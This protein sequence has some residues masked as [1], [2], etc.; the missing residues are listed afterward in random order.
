[1]CHSDPVGLP[2]KGNL[3]SWD[4]VVRSGNDQCHRC[5]SRT[6]CFFSFALDSKSSFWAKLI[7]QILKMV[8]IVIKWSNQKFPID[9]EDSTTAILLKSQIF[10][11]TGVAPE[12]QKIMVKGGMLKDG[13]ELKSLGL[14][15]VWLF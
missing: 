15:D 6:S 10:S 1:M 9:V 5:R 7:K 11:L 14:K 12:R 2:L 8:Q 4:V 3:L 13:T